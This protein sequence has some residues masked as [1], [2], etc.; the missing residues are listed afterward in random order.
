MKVLFDE[1]LSRRLADRLAD[2]YPDSDHVYSIGLAQRSDREIWEYARVNG[3]LIVTK[4]MDF[5]EL[6]ILLGF[7]PKVVWLRIGNCETIRVEAALRCKPRRL[8]RLGRSQ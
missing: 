3:S 5:N 8:D 7:P 1:N 4:D 6:S 2:L